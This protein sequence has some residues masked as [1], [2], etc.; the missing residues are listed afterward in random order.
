MSYYDLLEALARPGC[1]ICYLAKRTTYRY[2]DFLSYENVNDPGLR[3]RL[4]TAHG[5]CNYHAWQFVDDMDDG[6]GTAIIY[7]DI[8]TALEAMLTLAGAGSLDLLAGLRSGPRRHTNGLAKRLA[9][10]G[11]CPACYQL[12]VLTRVYVDTLLD[13]VDDPDLYAA[14]ARSTGLCLP[15]LGQ[16]LAR[17]ST[18]EQAQPLARTVGEAYTRLSADRLAAATVLPLL[19]GAPGAAFD[20]SPVLAASP[21]REPNV[22]VPEGGGCPVC[23]GALAASDARLHGLAS[24]GDESVGAL[25]NSHAARYL[26]L[27]LDG[28]DIWTRLLADWAGRLLAPASPAAASRRYATVLAALGRLAAPGP[29]AALARGLAP[30][31]ACPACL[32]RTSA[33]Q[34]L[35]A[36]AGRGEHGALCLSHFL[37]SLLNGTDAPALRALVAV[38]SQA[39]RDIIASLSKFIRKRDYRFT[40]EP[41]GEEADSPERAVALVAGARGLGGMGELP[42]AQSEGLERRQV[43]ARGRQR[44]AGD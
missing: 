14:L 35:S 3:A 27:G 10:R 12:D 18:W 4:R 17:A 7:R 11:E 28:G 5:F 21:G 32:A 1:P 33:E 29:G 30:H 40:H 26:A 13:H 42:G 25:C 24:A 19:A 43:H 36:Q 2:L 31:A 8:V 22:A 6:L 20:L 23:R 9:P 38:Q 44:G 39:N 16:A 37:L 15:H 34:A 41:P